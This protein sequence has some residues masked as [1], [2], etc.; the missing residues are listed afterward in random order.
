MPLTTALYTG[1]SG[2]T[3]NQV[4]LD[5][6]GNNISNA[7]T[8]AF[9]SARA[10]FQPQFSETSSFGSPPGTTF[11]GSNP[12][13]KGLGTL[14]GSV[15][16]NFADGNIRPTGFNKDL[17]IQ[18][19]G[20]FIVEDSDRYYTRYGH[21]ELNSAK[22]LIT[23]EGRHLMGYGIDENFNIIEGQLQELRVPTGQLTIARATSNVDMKGVLNADGEFGTAGTILQSQALTN[24][25]GGAVDGTTLLADLQDDGSQ[26]FFDGTT[27][28]FNGMRGERLQGE[29]ALDVTA[30]STVQ[31]LIDFL[32]GGFGINTDLTLD[33]PGGGAITD[34]GGGEYSIE[35]TGN[36]GTENGLAIGAGALQ[37]DSPLVPGPLVFTANQDAIGESTFTSMTVYDSLGS[38]MELNLTYVYE[39]A[40]N[41]GST[42]RFYANS[43]DDTDGSTVLG[44]GIIQFD[45]AGQYLSSTNTT[46]AIDR[47]NT[48]A[49]TPLSI[50]LNMTDIQGLIGLDDYLA[51]TNQDGM[52]AGTLEDFAIGRDGSIIGTFSNGTTRTLGQV[53]LASFANAEG[54]IDLGNS[55]FIA[56][57]NSGEAVIGA[58][59]AAG[60]G[61]V[62]G[63]A[64]ETSN[65]DISNEFINLIIASTGFSA[66]GR[67][68]TMANQLLTELMSMI[69]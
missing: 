8:T 44:S 14:L 65:V 13:Q 25:G 2:L 51:V 29:R 24:S 27:L 62:I 38:P 28:T 57:P 16:R 37:T 3:V 41:Q 17:A 42:W 36:V 34:L 11:G 20:M 31:D 19:D 56:G 48:G 9:K 43:P 5:V 26:A 40:G 49:V 54:L 7:N 53:A 50:T 59:K 46:L 47:D 64:V 30:T 39:S 60:N 61:E 23:P 58:P 66:S 10:I 63:G 21:F 32:V 67:V 52:A 68:I 18:G 6:I 4:A 69:R 45:T 15:Q 1:L 35:I 22:D 33:Y 55:T 12:V